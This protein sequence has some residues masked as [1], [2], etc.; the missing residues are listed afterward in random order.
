MMVQTATAAASPAAAAASETGA[1]PDADVPPAQRGGDVAYLW[2]LAGVTLLLG[3]AV[4]RLGS[5]GLTTLQA[6][7]EPAQWLILA[8]LT[9]GF[10]YMEGVRAFQQRWV[11]RVVGRLAALRTDR[12]AWYRA[13]APL[14]AMGFISPSVRTVAL[15]WG[16]TA[17]I[18]AAILVVSRFPDPWRGI[19]DIAV[20]AAL[21]YGTLALIVAAARSWRGA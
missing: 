18:V 3:T 9:A 8:G 12:R 21:L 11:P 20:A 5:R 10:V 17:L 1:E 15:S 19:V 2:G 4:L 14:H 6:G 16:G 7:L 13:L